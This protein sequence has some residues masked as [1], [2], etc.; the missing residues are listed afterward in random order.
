P[1][2]PAMPLPADGGYVTPG[3]WRRIYRS[4]VSYALLLPTFILLFVFSYYPA[5]RGILYAFQEVNPGVSQSWIGLDNFRKMFSDRLLWW[6]F[7]NL[8]SL[9]AGNLL[10]SI[11]LPLFVA[12]L[13]AR[14]ASSR[15]RYGWQTLFLFPIV[16]PGMVGI[17]LWRGF[18]YDYNMGLINQVLG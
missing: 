7:G 10:K 2:P 13:I 1:P 12:V 9:L 3:L 14:L 11:I 8:L 4:W 16:V 5:V 15:L 18:I 6:S 17:L